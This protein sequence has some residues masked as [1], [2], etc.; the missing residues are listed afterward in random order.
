[1][2]SSNK[3]SQA[4]RK[5]LIEL[6]ED[7]WGFTAAAREVGVGVKTTRNLWDWRRLHG[8]LVPMRKPSQVFYSFK[9]KLEAVK[10]FLAGQAKLHIA[11][12][13]RLSSPKV[14]ERR[15][16]TYR[17]HG[18]DGLYPKSKGRPPEASSSAAG[19]INELE[20]FQCRVEYLEAKNTYLK[21]LRD[22]MNNEF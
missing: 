6:F 7:G 3:A 18:E 21:A 15:V 10:H 5:R 17:V 4:Q 1:M 22:L 13:M 11:K 9:T 12:D 16:R 20:V 8:K 2:L 14:L 19:G